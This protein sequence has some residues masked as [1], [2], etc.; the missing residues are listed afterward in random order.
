MQSDMVVSGIG[1]EGGG[2]DEWCGHCGQ[3]GAGG[4]KMNVLIEKF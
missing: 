4:S 3:Q 1:Q 2:G